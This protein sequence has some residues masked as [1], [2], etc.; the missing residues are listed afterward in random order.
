M[1][2]QLTRISFIDALSICHDSLLKF[3]PSAYRALCSDSR[4]SILFRLFLTTFNLFSFLDDISEACNDVHNVINRLKNCLLLPT[5][6]TFINPASSTIFP[7]FKA[8]SSTGPSDFKNSSS[9]LALNF[10]YN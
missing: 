4:A 6:E 9:F 1:K 3:S 7:P 2:S 10:H 5:S 8:P